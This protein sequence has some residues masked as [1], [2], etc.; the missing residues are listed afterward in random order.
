MIARELMSA[1]SEAG[2]SPSG[3]TGE[4]LVTATN[5]SVQRLN[6]LEKPGWDK[7]VLAHRDAAFFHS[8]SW[9]RVL[10]DTYGHAP[11]YF[12]AANDE[13][14][15]SVL[16]VMEVN[17]PFTGRRGVGLPFTDEC[18]FL[19]DSSVAAEE[20]CQAVLS[21]GRIRKW[22]YV[23][24][25]G[26]KNLSKTASPSLSFF[27]HVLRLS[28]GEDRMFSRLES[29]VRRGIRKAER[30]NVRIEISQTMESVRAFYSLHCKTRRRH[31]LPPQSFSFFRSIFRN[32]LSKNLG[33]VVLG[34]F[35]EKPIVAAVFFHLGDKAIYK[36]GASES[37]FNRLCGNN[38]I[39]W[40]A[41]KWYSA[42]GFALLHFG[43]SSIANEGLRQFKLSF[44]TEEHKIDYFRYD[45]RQ[46]AFVTD[47]DKV[48]GWF[49]GVF[50]LM[51]MPLSR[52]FGILLYR[53][54]S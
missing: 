44:G 22:K 46:E 27:G 26:V 45:F 39:M 54:L 1:L 3:I 49:N 7:L 20:A 24:F 33:F 9:A 18:P 35:Q 40:E 32:V 17:S 52:I 43:R 13:Q 16:P 31:G 47:R 42:K 11:H 14:L 37:A 38:L 15:F 19:S 2:A 4:R 41:I 21:F 28:D 8:A 23:E 29:R 30:S 51:P 12:C 25:R 53:H 50:R 10:H 34:S 6:P 48:F 36:F 5:G